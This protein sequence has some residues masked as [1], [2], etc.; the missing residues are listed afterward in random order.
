MLS[1]HC[2]ILCVGQKPYRELPAYL[3]HSDVCFQYYRPIRKNN[4]GNSQKLFLY[5]AAGKP[6]VSTR[7]ADVESYG[8]YV[9]IVSTGSEFVEG[10]E[11]VLSVDDESQVEERQS[12]AG[13][14]SWQARCNRISEIWKKS[15]KL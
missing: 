1:G 8:R 10:V 14:N 6:V 3:V 9:T 7:S 2:N 11:N 13:R 12:F 4:S 5:L 15:G